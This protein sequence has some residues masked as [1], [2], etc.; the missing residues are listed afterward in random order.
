MV[1][2]KNVAYVGNNTSSPV[3]LKEKSIIPPPYPDSGVIYAGYSKKAL[4]NNEYRLIPQQK[5]VIHKSVTGLSSA[6]IYDV[7]LGKKLVIGSMLL[8]NNYSGGGVDEIYITDG[9]SGVIPP[10][11]IQLYYRFVAY[12]LFNPLF[13]PKI[14]INNS[15]WVGITSGTVDITIYGHLEDK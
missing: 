9:D 6:S 5:I 1:K 8:S 15:V 11:R 12:N 10:Q 7:P 4:S 13:E 2:N 14:E 3:D